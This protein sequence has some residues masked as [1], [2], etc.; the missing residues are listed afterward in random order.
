MDG[1]DIDEF[2]STNR[3][4]LSGYAMWLI[5]EGWMASKLATLTA[6]AG[7]GGKKEAAKQAMDDG[8]IL[9]RMIE[10][11]L[12]SSMDTQAESGAS[13]PYQSRGVFSWLSPSAQTTLPVPEDYRPASACRYTGAVA[14]Y[15]DTAIE[16][17]L[18]AAAAAKLAAV[19]LTLFAGLTLKRKMSTWGQRLTDEG[20]KTAILAMNQDAKDRRLLE[21]I[22]FFEFD[23]GKVRAIP[24]WHLLCDSETGAATDSTLRSGAGVDMSMW[25]LRFLQKPTAW[26]D[27]QKS[28]G[29]RGY[30]DAV[31]SLECGNPLGQIVTEPAS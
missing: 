1:T 2:S 9:A 30:H 20:S 5:T 27:P 6:T 4:K 13:T 17:Q 19:D 21:V 10:K 11:Q 8:I 3:D 12:L 28:G 24:T 26:R 15:T 22:D 14:D 25:K 29:P 16:A 7:V 18:A 31:Y 23:A